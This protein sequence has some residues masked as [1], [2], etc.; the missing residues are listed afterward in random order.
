MKA[1]TLKELLVINT[2]VEAALKAR[3]TPLLKTLVQ[4]DAED[5]PAECLEVQF[6]Q[7]AWTGHW[8]VTPLGKMEHAAWTYQLRVNVRTKRVA[9]PQALHSD[10]TGAMR[11]LLRAAFLDPDLLPFHSLASMDEQSASEQVAVADDQDVSSLSYSGLIV[12]KDDAWPA[13]V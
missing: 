1:T 2:G 6:L 5:I 4:R 3:F 11:E 9:D 8:G 10:Y 7:G 13:D 12:V